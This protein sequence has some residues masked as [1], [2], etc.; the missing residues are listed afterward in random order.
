[1]LLAAGWLSWS[2]PPP[3]PQDARTALERAERVYHGIQTLSAEFTQTIEN[4]ML[5]EPEVS[6]GELSLAPPDR[7]AM[8][9]T[10]P[11]GDLIVA[12]GTWLWIYAPSSVPDQAFRQPV[13]A[14][15]P[16]SPN[17]IGQFVQR[18]LERYQATYVGV[19]SVGGELADIVS[20][21]PRSDALP[22][23][24]AELALSRQSALPRRITVVER[25]GQ[26]RTLMFTAIRVNQP[27]Q[28][29]VFRF[30]APDGV[31]VIVPDS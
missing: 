16:A 28:A 6:R 1:M 11:A 10:D 30:S 22:F 25:S 27:I 2:T 29:S 18:P 26:R 20:L 9:F 7:F 21:V 3:L 31:R 5:G 4:P 15:G 8:R 13:P 19:D 12:D 17:L 14:Q 23:A 24:R